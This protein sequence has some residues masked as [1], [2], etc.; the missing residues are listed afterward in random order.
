M[1]RTF[2][3]VCCGMQK[4]A[5]PKLKG[6]QRYCSDHECQKARKAAWQRQKT[7]SDPEYRSDQ[8]ERLIS[9][10]KHR[11]LHQYQAQYR[12]RHPE[13][14]EDNRRAQKLRNWKRGQTSDLIVKMDASTDINT[15]TYI[16]TPLRRNKAGMIVKM[17]ALLVQLAVFQRLNGSGRS[18]NRDCK[19]GLY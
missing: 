13:Y 8:K 2:I 9:W 5:N 19:N 4:A 3:C 10:R 15:D 6:K 14:V 16:L 12:R 11:P 7:A 1:Q 17:D 18:P